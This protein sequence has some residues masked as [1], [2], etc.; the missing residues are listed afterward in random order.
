MLSA[1]RVS[2]PLA[3]PQEC[4]FPPGVL[5]PIIWCLLWPFL[6]PLW[7]QWSQWSLSLCLNLSSLLTIPC[8][9]FLNWALGCRLFDHEHCVCSP[10]VEFIRICVPCL[11]T[12]WEWRHIFHAFPHILAELRAIYLLGPVTKPSVC[13]HIFSYE[14]KIF[15]HP[16]SFWHGNKVKATSSQLNVLASPILESSLPYEEGCIGNLSMCQEISCKHCCSHLSP[17]VKVYQ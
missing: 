12:F 4:I 10:W 14:Y 15:W 1:A 16:P 11:L 2:P 8:T 6:S 13:L 3:G 9:V 5:V 17:D 7:S